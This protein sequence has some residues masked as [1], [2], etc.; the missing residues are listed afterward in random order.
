[1]TFILV[2]LNLNNRN[3]KHNID[4]GFPI[5]MRIGDVGA[6]SHIGDLLAFS[7]SVVLVMSLIYQVEF[8]NKGY[9]AREEDDWISVII[10]IRSWTGFDPDQDGMVD[11]DGIHDRLSKFQDPFPFQFEVFVSFFVV[12]CSFN[13]TFNE[14]SL[15]S[16]GSDPSNN[17]LIHSCSILANYENSI[18][19]CL[20]RISILGDMK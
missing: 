7:L 2:F 9:E 3:K 1:M 14:G 13:M 11:L 12:E 5:S 6:V 8:S 17:G 20:I 19:P 18:L 16:D 4:R 15:I 10:S